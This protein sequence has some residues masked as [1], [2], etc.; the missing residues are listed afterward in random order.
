M[1]HNLCFVISALLRAT[2]S[3]EDQIIYKEIEILKRMN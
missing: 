3:Y 1:Q 2:K